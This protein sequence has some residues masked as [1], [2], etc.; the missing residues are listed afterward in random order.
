MCVSVWV[1]MWGGNHLSELICVNLCN[2]CQRR[3]ANFECLI[4]NEIFFA[5]CDLICAISVILFAKV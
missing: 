1:F 5:K 4:L 2:Q 3:F